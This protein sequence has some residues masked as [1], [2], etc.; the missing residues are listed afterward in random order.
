MSNVSGQHIYGTI[1]ISKNG[2]WHYTIQYNKHTY[3]NMKA[4]SSYLLKPPT[5]LQKEKSS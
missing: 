4:N 3:N 5:T 2:Y 1:L